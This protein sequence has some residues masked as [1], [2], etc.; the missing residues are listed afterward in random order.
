MMVLKRCKA[1][2]CIEPW[3]VLHPH[4]KV[5]SLKDALNP[6]FDAFYAKMLEENAVSFSGCEP[7]QILSAEGPQQAGVYGHGISLSQWT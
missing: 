7:G 4:G 3:S 2:E 1:N 6:K 5:D